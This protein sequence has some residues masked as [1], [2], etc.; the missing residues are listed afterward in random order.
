MRSSVAHASKQRYY[1]Q[2][3]QHA[4]LPPPQ[5]AAVARYVF[6]PYYLRYCSFSPP[7]GGMMMSWPQHAANDV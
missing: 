7:A 3:V 1:K 2:A 4:N 6:M 5:S